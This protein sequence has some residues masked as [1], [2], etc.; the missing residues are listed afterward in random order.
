MT[1]SNLLHKSNEKKTSALVDPV[2][3]MAVDPDAAA[4]SYEHKGKTYYFCSKHCLEKFRAD[5][6]LFLNQAKKS[7]QPIGTQGAGWKSS[8]DD[9]VAATTPRGLPARGPRSAPG[10]DRI[11]YTCPMH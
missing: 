8:A 7:I 11:T 2:C 5:P 9:P 1:S 4:G 10:S 6:E 3:G